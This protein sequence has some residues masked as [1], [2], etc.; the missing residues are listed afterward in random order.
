MSRENKKVNNNS[1]SDSNMIGSPDLAELSTKDLF[2]LITP[3]IAVQ[4][5]IYT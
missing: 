2:A 5:I 3:D 1:S 4:V